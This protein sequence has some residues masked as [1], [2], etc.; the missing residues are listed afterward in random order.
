MH[1]ERQDFIL[2]SLMHITLPSTSY[3]PEDELLLS[4]SALSARTVDV[5]QYMGLWTAYFPCPLQNLYKKMH[6]K[7]DWHVI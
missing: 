4:P 2:D 7:Y 3:V 1:A 6:K 5:S